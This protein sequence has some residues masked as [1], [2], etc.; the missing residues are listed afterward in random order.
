MFVLF[1]VSFFFFLI[2]FFLKRGVCF[3]CAPSLLSP[4]P[5]PIPPLLLCQ[6]VLLVTFRGS[7]CCR[8][9]CHRFFCVCFVFFLDL[10]CRLFSSHVSFT[11]LVSK[12]ELVFASPC[13]PPP[14]LPKLPTP[15]PP[16]GK[17]A[18]GTFCLKWPTDFTLVAKGVSWLME[19]SSR[20]GRRADEFRHKTSSGRVA[21]LW[22]QLFERVKSVL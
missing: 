6:P 4:P 13:H 11:R 7:L 8:C 17:K 14:S 16:K 18:H 19:R 10:S 1:L 5:P 12:P 22:P 3:F 2:V 21:H 15:P 9:G 20:Q